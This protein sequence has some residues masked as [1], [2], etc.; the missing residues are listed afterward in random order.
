MK[1]VVTFS[2]S[3]TLDLP[4]KPRA[5]YCPGHT[6]GHAAFYLPDRR[7][8]FTGDA[9]VTRDLLANHD[10]DP[11]LMPDIFHTDPAQARASLDVLAALDTDL[12]LPGHGSPYAGQ[13]ADAVAIARR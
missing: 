10:G 3:E 9:L 13:A 11:Q 5:V 6:V 4:G 8:L 12:L 7:I 2:D 1:S